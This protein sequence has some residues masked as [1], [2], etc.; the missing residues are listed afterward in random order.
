MTALLLNYFLLDLLSAFD[1]ISHDILFTCLNG[2]GITDNA[3]DFYNSYITKRSSSVLIGNA[4]LVCA[5]STHGVPQ[6]RVLGPL[7]YSL[8]INLLRYLLK[9]VPNIKYFVYADDI[10]LLS[11]FSHNHNMPKNQDLCLSA[12]TIRNWLLENNLLLNK[13]ET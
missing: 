6:G 1:R 2:V 7:L 10:Q 5:C 13:N 8:Y 11:I 9:S 12:N 4:I 3:F